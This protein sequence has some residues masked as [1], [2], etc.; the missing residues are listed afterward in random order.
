[1]DKSAA[2]F[3]SL[4][5]LAGESGLGGEFE[6]AAEQAEIASA[7]QAHQVTSL[8]GERV[9]TAPFGDEALEDIFLV[10]RG[11]A[12]LLEHTT[13]ERFVDE[14]PIFFREQKVHQHLADPD[15]QIVDDDVATD[16]EE[17][18]G[19]I[20]VDERLRKSVAPV[21]QRKVEVLVFDLRQNLFG[22]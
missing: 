4:A 21:D 1:M 12:E 18:R 2:A 14:F 16:L 20:P 11:I 22:N 13:A 7:Q 15:V 19:V 3:G 8:G 10:V 9:R 17:I 6:G 5:E